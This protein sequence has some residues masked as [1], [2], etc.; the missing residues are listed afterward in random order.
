MEKIIH[1]IWVGK[2]NIPI[3]E[4]KMISQLKEINK[5]TQHIL[6]ID[7]DPDLPENLKY[8]Y[9]I[10][11]SQNDF[12]FCADILRIWYVYK[13]GGF[14]LDVDWNIQ[15]P[16]DGLFQYN[17]VFFNHDGTDYTIPNGI[18]GA[19]KN[20]EILKHCIETVSPRY[21]WFGPSWFGD[22]IRSYFK[23]PHAHPHAE[24]KKSLEERGY[25]Y[26]LFYKF[27]Q[28]FGRHEALHSWCPE[29]K[30]KFA[31]NEQL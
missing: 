21:G 4:Q 23:F 12:A 28:E 7:T 26:Y 20:C 9:D 24:L 1:Q 13:Y 10:Y 18:F 16:I 17:G 27:E 3:K 31:E 2:Y 5:N 19:K 25:N 29:G 14:Y 6:W 22:I 11:Y 30:K 15:K 8:W